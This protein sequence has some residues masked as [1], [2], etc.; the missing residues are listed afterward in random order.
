MK[1]RCECDL[2]FIHFIY[3][4][5]FGPPPPFTWP[6]PTNDQSHF[7]SHLFAWV[8]TIIR[9]LHEKQAHSQPG[10]NVRDFSFWGLGWYKNMILVL[11][12]LQLVVFA[13]SL[14]FLK[15]K[16][17]LFLWLHHLDL[18]LGLSTNNSRAG[19][20]VGPTCSRHL[21]VAHIDP[22]SKFL[23]LDPIFFNQALK[24]KIDI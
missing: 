19:W 14:S 23:F 8:I 24:S 20:D 10:V 15:I 5:F 16:T 11:W 3:I 7:I 12:M 22:A 21:Y 1:L 4:I 13:L 18:R 17:V 9:E 6:Y 2:K